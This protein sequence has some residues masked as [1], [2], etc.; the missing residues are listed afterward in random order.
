MGQPPSSD[1]I[2]SLFWR[3]PARPFGEEPRVVDRAV[4]VTDLVPTI[5]QA[6]DMTYNEKFDGRRWFDGKPL[7]EAFTVGGR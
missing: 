7:V 6:L 3:E 1:Y 4:R 5:L 2:V